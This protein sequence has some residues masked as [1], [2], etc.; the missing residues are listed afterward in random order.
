MAMIGSFPARGLVWSWL[1]AGVVDDGRLHRTEEGTPQGGVVSPVLLNI[2]LHGMETAAGVRYLSSGSIRV[3]SPA[4]IRYADDLVVLCHTRQDAALIKARLARWLEPRGLAF[5]EAKTR[6]VNLNEGFD[7]LGFNVRRYGQTPLIRPSKTAVRRIRERLRDE[8]RSLRG[9]NAQA[10]IKRL[11]PIIRG[12]AAYYRT[13]VSAKV[14]GDLDHYLWQLTYKWAAFSHANKPTSWVIARYF[15][16]FNRS[17]QD[18]WVFGDRASGAYLH[19]FAWTG[20]VRHQIVKYRASPDDP[21]LGEYWAAR[22]RKI[23]LPVNRTNQWLYRAQDGRCHA[24]RGTL[25]VIADR[26]QTPTDWERWLLAERIAITMITVPTAGTTG[27]AEPRLIHTDC[28]N[29]DHP[30]LRQHANRAC[31]SRMH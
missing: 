25:P 20:I 21:A 28:L 16:R 17:R 6:V 12:W 1:R 29:R 18:R 22:R 7:F 30:P 27:T 10:V 4:L 9:S 26:P 8:L 15:G 5:N 3:D 11:N 31:L 19:R 23:P 2:A 13:Q 14:F 24:C